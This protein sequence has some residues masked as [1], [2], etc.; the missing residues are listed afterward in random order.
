M[1]LKEVIIKKQFVDGY[2]FI[3]PLSFFSW[4]GVA[5]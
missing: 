4:G 1:C 2:L 5:I 3:F